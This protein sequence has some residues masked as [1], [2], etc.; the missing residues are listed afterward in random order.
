MSNVKVSWVLPVYN[1]EKFLSKTIES[2]ISQTFSNWELIVIDDGSTDNSL[3]IIKSFDDDRIKIISRENKGLSETLNE[4]VSLSQGNYIARIDA[5]DINEPN[6]LF[7]QVSFL[8]SHLDYVLVA[9]NVSFIDENDKIFNYSTLPSC[10]NKIKEKL[11]IDNCIFHPS[12]L[13][14]RDALLNVGGYDNKVGCYWEDYQLWLKLI[15]EGRFYI[16]PRFL[17]KYRVHD[18]SISK[19][20]PEY[21]A[22]DIIDFKVKNGNIGFDSKIVKFIKMKLSKL[23]SIKLLSLLVINLRSIAKI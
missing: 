14:R 10:H 21:I 2:V 5:D 12:V 22:S 20:T 15:N 17:L 8:D 4:G 7:E 19:N 13:M 6:R 9:S 3:N 23:K 18:K 16:L 11:N 1:A